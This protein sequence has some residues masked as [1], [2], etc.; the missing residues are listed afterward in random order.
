MEEYIRNPNTKCKICKKPVYKRPVEIERNKGSV[1]CGQAC[2]GISCRKEVPCA[3]CGK[4]ILGGLNKKT[5]SRGC[6]NTHRAGL[7]YKRGRPRDKASGTRALKRLIIEERGGHCERCHYDKTRII[8]VHHKDRDKT[9][10][11]L[12]NLELL[13]P[14]CHMEEHHL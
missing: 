10:N 2:Y 4:L 12:N 9:N 1:Y 11:T 7:K 5:C 3:T 13:C 6:A 8:Q 14:N